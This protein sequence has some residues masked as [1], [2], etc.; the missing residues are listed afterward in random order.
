MNKMQKIIVLLAFTLVSLALTTSAFAHVGIDPDTAPK[1]SS[2]AF[3]I[4]VPNESA[5]ASTIK[6]EFSFP[7]DTPIQDAVPTL[8]D[9]WK[10]DSAYSDD[11]K[12]INTVTLTGGKIEGSKKVGFTFN[13]V[14]LPGDTDQ[15]LIKAVQTYDDGEIV[16]WVDE[17][18]ASGEEP[19]YPAAVLKLTGDNIENTTTTVSE[20]QQSTSKT[21][22]KVDKE[23]KKD[24]PSTIIYAIVG[25][26]LVLILILGIRFFLKN[27]KPTSENK[28]SDSE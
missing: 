27:S 14:G 26:V 17:P 3:T 23:A 28:T 24:N 9:E 10:A 16:R 25:A 1:G 8:F 4:N 18:L 13:L 20:I 5:A 7:S 12:Y 22:E 6:L 2:G 19:E 21:A 11:G 15:I